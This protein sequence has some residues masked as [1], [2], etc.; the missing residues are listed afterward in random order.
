MTYRRLSIGSQ[1]TFL[2]LALMI[3][4]SPIAVE[5]QPLSLDGIGSESRDAALIEQVASDEAVVSLQPTA[6]LTPTM[7]ISQTLSD[8]AQRNTIAF[9]GLAFLTG[10]LGADSFFPPGKVADFWG[11][12]YL[13]DNDPSQMGHNP[14]FLTSAAFNMWNVLTA[15]QRAQLEVLANNQVSS[16]SDYA[17]R[18]FILMKAFRRLLEGNV[19]AGSPGL[20]EATVR[21]YSFGSFYLKDTPV[22]ST[23][24]SID[25]NL[26]ATAG[27]T[28][29]LTLT[30]TQAA[31]V[32]DLVDIQ[33]QDLYE[34]VDRRSDILHNQST[35]LYGQ[36][37]WDRDRP[38][39]GAGLAADRWR[40]D[41][42]VKRR[43]LLSESRAGRI[44]RLALAF[45]SR[46]L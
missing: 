44:R 38:G 28:F 18:R 29:L 23:G 33:R 12:Q 9:D 32:T 16:I 39:N 5:V 36:W 13:R 11:F 46:A 43:D 21:A 42:L 31:L 10:S 3:A 37:Q 25:P 17:Y 6:P 19:P 14:L 27:I 8:E 45:Q 2:L 15:D 7:T 40:R 20:D 30:P 35:D 26:T 22:M 24:G 41:D 4:A 1:A 34:I